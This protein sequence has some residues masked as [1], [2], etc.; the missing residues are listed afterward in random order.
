[1]HERRP[2]AP[3]A[4]RRIVT[5]GSV[6]LYTRGHRCAAAGPLG[7]LEAPRAHVHAPACGRPN[8]DAAKRREEDYADARVDGRPVLCEEA[9]RGA[10][11]LN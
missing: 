4:I 1:M 8:A 5:F 7:S 11:R 10:E 6:L 2:Y 3:A 9:R